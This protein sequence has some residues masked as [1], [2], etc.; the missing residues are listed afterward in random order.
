MYHNYV[1][2]AR[3]HGLRGPAGLLKIALSSRG[4]VGAAV[5]GVLDRVLVEL[6]VRA[7]EGS[8]LQAVGQVLHALRM[9]EGAGKIDLTVVLQKVFL[10]SSCV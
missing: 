3:D 4:S 8:T 5:R 2:A 7:T 1:Q 9:A 6:A 10:I